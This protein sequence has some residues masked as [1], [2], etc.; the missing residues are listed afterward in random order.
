MISN[1]ML[2]YSLYNY[3][4]CYLK[5][6]SNYIGNYLGP[7]SMDFSLGFFVTKMGVHKTPLPE[8]FLPNPTTPKPV[9]GFRI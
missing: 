7:Y 9:E 4:I 8:T 5:Q 6:T 2:P 3:S 1:I